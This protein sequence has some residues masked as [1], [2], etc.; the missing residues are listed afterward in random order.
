MKG[1]F[2]KIIFT[3]CAVLG[4]ILIAGAVLLICYDQKRS[5]A[6]EIQAKMLTEKLYAAMPAGV[7]GVFNEDSDADAAPPTYVIDGVGYIGVLRA[8]AADIEVPVADEAVD[9][10]PLR[11]SGNAG[12][13]SL[14][15]GGTYKGFS[16][17]SVG[18][19]LVLRDVRG[20]VWHYSVFEMLRGEFDSEDIPEDIKLILEYEYKGTKI[21]VLCR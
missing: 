4:V 3:L 12:A 8:P 16:A 1:A 2:S 7:D 10:L 14:Y 5:S 17:L 20:N 6:A 18:N 21:T 11:I 13:G 9:L 15:I 19:A